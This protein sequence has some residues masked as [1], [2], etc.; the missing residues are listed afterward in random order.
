MDACWRQGDADREQCR[1]RA[2][3]GRG[4]MTALPRIL[5]VALAVVIVSNLGVA[6]AAAQG[7][8]RGKVVRASSG[9]PLRRVLI[10]VT[11]TDGARV[12]QVLSGV[13]GRYE[14]RDLPRG[15]YSVRASKSGFVAMYYGQRYPFQLARRAI[16]VETATENIDLALTPAGA[17]S[18]VVLDDG[19]EPLTGATVTAARLRVVNGRRTLALVSRSRPTNDLGEFRV[20][21]LAEGEYII[22]VA[23]RLE[24]GDNIV[25]EYLPTY[26]PGTSSVA[27]AQRVRVRFGEEVSGLVLPVIA[28][29]TATISGTVTGAGEA[30]RVRVTLGHE[31]LGGITWHYAD[32]GR[33]GEFRFQERAAWQLYGRGLPQDA[34]G[35][36][37]RDRRGAARRPRCPRHARS[38]AA[39]N[40]AR[41]DPL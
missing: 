39:A 24:T 30:G 2:A 6:S 17:L 5:L 36:I 13:D 37:E 31:Y 25:V 20:S 22:G 4:P 14:V 3:A 33:D 9:E 7:T 32:A 40:D 26:Y 35:H 1:R 8:I 18:G 34:R 38:A 27:D 11:A 23:P 28:S 21:G 19:G 29:R 16:T 10:E 15:S 41:T 12:R